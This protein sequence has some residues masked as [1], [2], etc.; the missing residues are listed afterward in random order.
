[1]T[2][3]GGHG[4]RGDALARGDLGTPLLDR[5]DQVGALRPEVGPVGVQRVVAVAGGRRP[6]L[7]EP[8]AVDELAEQRRADGV[9]G[10]V[11]CLP[12][13]STR[14][15]FACQGIATGGDAR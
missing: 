5:G 1:M 3:S 13:A 4:A 9:G 12:E 11:T 7:E 6:R 8:V 2:A 10:A 15:P 14:E